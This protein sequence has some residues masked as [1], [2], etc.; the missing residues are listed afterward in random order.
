MKISKNASGEAHN[1]RNCRQFC[2]QM[3]LNIDSLNSS[4]LTAFAAEKA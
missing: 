2:S 3:P 1:N 4:Q